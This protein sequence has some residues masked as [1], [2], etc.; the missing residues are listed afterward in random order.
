L[1]DVTKL[2]VESAYDAGRGLG[3]SNGR[4]AEVNNALAALPRPASGIDAPTKFV[5]WFRGF[6]SMAESAAMRAV[7]V[8]TQGVSEFQTNPLIAAAA[9]S[10]AGTVARKLSQDS[11]LGVLAADLQIADR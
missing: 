3:G 8:G 7:E 4:Y 5:S 1:R 9:G 11:F 10:F 6:G 2:I